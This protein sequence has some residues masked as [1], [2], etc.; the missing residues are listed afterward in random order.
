VALALL[1]P[2]R[3]VAAAADPV[4]AAA[5]LAYR[6]PLCQGAATPAAGTSTA[7]ASASATTVGDRPCRRQPLRAVPLLAGCLPVGAEPVVGRPLRLPPRSD[8][9]RAPPPCGLA[10]VA[11][12]RPFAG[13]LAVVGRSIAWWPWLQPAAPCRGSGSNRPPPCRGALFAADR[14]CK[15]AGR[16]HARWPFARASFATKM[17][18]ERVERFYTIQ[19]HH[20]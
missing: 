9:G 8:R 1:H 12:G 10:L 19:S 11:N 16:G 3:A 13:G 18:Q 15:G 20:T 2:H 14:P 4:Q 6:Q 5:A 17:Q 7:A